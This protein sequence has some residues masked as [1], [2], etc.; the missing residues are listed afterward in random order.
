MTDKPAEHTVP[1]WARAIIDNY[2]RS[3]KLGHH[4]TDLMIFQR[5]EECRGMDPQDIEDGVGDL[6]D[7]HPE[8]DSK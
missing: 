3:Q 4:I 8:P 2:R 1:S 7:E 5:L 6:R